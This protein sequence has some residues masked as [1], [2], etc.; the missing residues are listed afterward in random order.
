ME[1]VIRDIWEYLQLS[2]EHELSIS[3]CS[4]GLVNI[5]GASHMR[6][7]IY[8]KAFLIDNYNED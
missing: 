4:S 6:R 7:K 1:N 8:L 5:E 3:V 2:V